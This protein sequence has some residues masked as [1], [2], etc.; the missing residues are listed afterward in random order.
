VYT[1]ENRYDL[2]LGYVQD[3][4]LPGRILGWGLGGGIIWSGVNY[5]KT[6]WVTLGRYLV[7]VGG[8]WPLVMES[9]F[10]RRVTLTAEANTWV[11]IEKGLPHE[12]LLLK[13]EPMGYE[14]RIVTD[15]NGYADIDIWD[16]ISADMEGGHTG[17]VKITIS[18]DRDPS[19]PLQSTISY[20]R[21]Q[22]I[23]EGR[24][25]GAARALH[26]ARVYRAYVSQYPSGRFRKAAEAFAREL[27][28]K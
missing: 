19:T 24:V 10:P 8:L 25:W 7:G 1:T 21:L 2:R 20:V 14:G 11:E 27:G 4:T 22:Q 26:N 3:L 6:G 16:H 18:L 17:G 9:I 15:V 23:E 13:I 28:S 12:I 5:Y